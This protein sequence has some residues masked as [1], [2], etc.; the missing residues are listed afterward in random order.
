MIKLNYEGKTY[1][2]NEDYKLSPHNEFL[3]KILD[4]AVDAYGYPS[5][6]FKTSFVGSQLEKYGAEIIEIYDKEMEEAPPNRIY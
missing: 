5:Q 2:I 1:N 6:G 4:N 3:V